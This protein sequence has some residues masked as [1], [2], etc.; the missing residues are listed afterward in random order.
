MA[1]DLLEVPEPLQAETTRDPLGFD[2]GYLARLRNGD[3]ETA[4]HFDRHFRRLVRL[5]LWHRFNGD[6]AQSLIDDCMAV[7]LENVLRGE[8][9]DATRLS[10]YVCGI[11]SNLV[12]KEMRPRPARQCVDLDIERLSDPGETIEEKLLAHER[13]KAVREVLDMLSVRD[14]NLLTEMFYNDLSRDEICAKYGLTRAQ[15][16]V[17]LFHARCRFQRT[18]VRKFAAEF[19]P[20]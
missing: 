10:A 6:R 14:R 5:K 20:I 4:K 9:K 13:A 17:A 19:A 18:W 12:K 2:E 8:P 7:A 3:D 11:C 16:R 1:A 15:L